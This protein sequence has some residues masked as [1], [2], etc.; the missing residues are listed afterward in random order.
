MRRTHM[1]V[2]DNSPLAFEHFDPTSKP[3]PPGHAHRGP[4]GVG[5]HTCSQPP[6]LRLQEWLVSMSEVEGRRML[7]VLCHIKYTSIS[8]CYTIVT[9]VTDKILP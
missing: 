2:A 9:V 7:S 8:E 3:E 5:K 1:H 6:L 4:F